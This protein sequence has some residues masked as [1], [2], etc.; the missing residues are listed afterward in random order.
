MKQSVFYKF[1]ALMIVSLI[2]VALYFWWAH[3]QF[4]QDSLPWWFSSKTIQKQ[5]SGIQDITWSLYISSQALDSILVDMKDTTALSFQTYDFT[6]KR[7]K[8]AFKTLLSNGVS[9]RMIIEDKKFQQYKNTFKEIQELFSWYTNFWIKSDKQMKTNYTHSKIMLTDTTFWIQTANLTHSSLFSNREYFF[10]SQNS[11]VYTSLQTVFE[12]DWNGET[13]LAEDIHPNL[14]ICPLNCRWIVQELLTLAQESIIIETQYITDE[15]LFSLLEEK[16]GIEELRILVS[17]TQSND[18]LMKRF[19]SSLVRK[20]SKPYLH[21]KMILIDHKILLLGSMNLSSTSLDENREIGILL[22][23]PL[24]ITQF[25][26][27]FEKD[28]EDSYK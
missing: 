11:W 7:I 12:K 27:Q 28:W 21:A 10:S 5:L 6:E 16:K 8:E 24:L 18:E 17:D 9:I 20:L 14:V 15:T 26:N 2:G 1:W 23:D 13:I 4:W 19:W 3:I 25:T 22:L